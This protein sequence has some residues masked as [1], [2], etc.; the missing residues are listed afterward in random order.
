MGKEVGLLEGLTSAIADTLYETA[1]VL[2]CRSVGLQA[3]GTAD[4]T[5][6]GLYRWPT[7]G[8]FV[9]SGVEY[10]YSGATITPT[11]AQLTGVAQYPSGTAG[12]AASARQGSIVAYSSANLT[13]LDA[14]RSAYFVDTASGSDLDTLARNYGLSRPRGMVDVMFRALLRV[15]MYLD[16]TTIDA[17]EKVLDVI[18]GAG[19]YEVW[20]T[21][22]DPDDHHKVFV[23]LA[24][25][26]T[27]I[28]EGK[29]FLAGG[30]SQPTTGATVTTTYTPS[31][32]YGVYENTTGDYARDRVSNPNLLYQPYAATT[33]AA[34]PTRI[35]TATST[36]LASDV[37][38]AVIVPATG[39]IWPIH[40]RT[41]ATQV[42]VSSA[43]NTGEIT[44]AAPGILSSPAGAFRSWMLGG[45]ATITHA[46][47]PVNVQSGTISEVISPW[48][49]RLSPMSGGG[50]VGVDNSVTFTVAPNFATASITI[51]LPRYSVVASTVTAPSTLPANVWVDYA[52]IESAQLKRNA[53]ESGEAQ[54]PFYLFDDTFFASTVLDDILAAGCHPVIERD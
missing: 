3:E 25:S 51:V 17:V 26:P 33:A 20:D 6:D 1:G 13:D 47:D 23:S 2:I 46:A 27:T 18:V 39:E 4:L 37:G 29:A 22:L 19:N 9:L 15:L 28:S 21:P 10:T 16:A 36:F 48:K 12:L 43:G 50:W 5:V 30:E 44:L 52:T 40:T 53:N 49:V 11:L 38:L 31:V 8:R 24:A 42:E 14:A 34:F 35:T 32:V 41:S 45:T 54:D 7:S